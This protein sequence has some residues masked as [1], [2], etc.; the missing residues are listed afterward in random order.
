MSRELAVH[1]P[2][3]EEVNK[4]LTQKNSLPNVGDYYKD[5]SGNFYQ[6]KRILDDR[7]EFDFIDT[8]G[9]GEYKSMKRFPL[10]DNV[11]YLSLEYTP[12]S[13]S[14]FLTL[15]DLT[16]VEDVEL[17]HSVG[18]PPLPINAPKNV[19]KKPNPLDTQVGGDHYKSLPIQ[20][21]EYNFF[22][23]IPY[24]E[25]NIIKYITRWRTKN[26][27][28][29]LEKAKHYIELLIELEKRKQDKE[30]KILPF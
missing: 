22:N 6:V 25:G 21:V 18:S 23:D 27:I 24:M 30:K 29:D 2:T 26:G 5:S 8:T 20:V 9:K 7:I 13:S 16:K 17:I 12:E 15:E 1:V 3:L 11:R 10:K 4:I 19:Q 14:K 28:Q